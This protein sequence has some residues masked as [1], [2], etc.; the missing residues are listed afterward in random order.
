MH[1]LEPVSCSEFLNST[2]VAWQLNGLKVATDLVPDCTILFQPHVAGLQ[3][4][5]LRVS[6]S[7]TVKFPR[8]WRSGHERTNSCKPQP[9]PVTSSSNSS[10]S[11]ASST[12]G[13]INLNNISTLDMLLTWMPCASYQRHQIMVKGASGQDVPARLKSTVAGGIW[14]N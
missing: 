8:W 10:S 1:N 7:L 11:S 4:H 5:K 14:W 2:L 9:K 13:A 12:S 6:S 3:T